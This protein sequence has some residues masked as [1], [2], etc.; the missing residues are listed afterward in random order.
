[1]A[2]DT[3]T[4]NPKNRKTGKTRLAPGPETEKTAKPKKTVS[5]TEETEK[6][7]FR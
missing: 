5:G 2:T 1:L 6:T 7:P 3:E 4:G